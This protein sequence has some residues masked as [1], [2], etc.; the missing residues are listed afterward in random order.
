MGLWVSGKR[1]SIIQR[2]LRNF[3]YPEVCEILER[4]LEIL[5]LGIYICVGI[6]YRAESAALGHFSVSIFFGQVDKKSNNK[7][8]IW[9][10]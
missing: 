2:Q 7:Y 4:L 9:Y 3:V 6:V 1:R 10:A 8:V 5:I